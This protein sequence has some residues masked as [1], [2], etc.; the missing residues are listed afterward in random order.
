MSIELHGTREKF[1]G[2]SARDGISGYRLFPCRMLLEFNFRDGRT[3][4]RRKYIIEFWRGVPGES[5]SSA[6]VEFASIS[7][8]RRANPSDR[9]EVVM[10]IYLYEIN[11]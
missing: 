6:R 5:S 10:G 7:H 11:L 2:C 4:G 1:N 9:M 8:R 3:V